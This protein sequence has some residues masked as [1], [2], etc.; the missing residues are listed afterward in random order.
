MNIR[1]P[2]HAWLP[3]AMLLCIVIAG[4][5]W[6]SHM[7]YEVA[8]S[9]QRVQQ[10]QQLLKV[11]INKLKLELA[12]MARP[13]RLRHLAKSKLGMLPPRPLQVIRP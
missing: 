6:L 4:Q 12:S 3:V 13:E 8:Q 9:A 2:F 7:R 10:E 5:I 11:E 1:N